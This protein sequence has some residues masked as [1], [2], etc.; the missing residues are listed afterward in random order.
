MTF[1]YIKTQTSTVTVKWGYYQIFHKNLWIY[2]VCKVCYFNAMLY[3]YRPQIQ[4]ANTGFPKSQSSNVVSDEYKLDIGDDWNKENV[5]D[6][7]PPKLLNLGDLDYMLS[8]V[9]LPKLR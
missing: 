7:R 5:S 6:L 1:D 8:P 3:N 9:E 2:A 4:R